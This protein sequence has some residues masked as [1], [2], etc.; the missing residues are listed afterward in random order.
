MTKATQ[1]AAKPA[2]TAAKKASA[3]K[4]A[5]ARKA[6]VAKA[7]GAGK[8]APKKQAVAKRAPVPEDQ[9]R[10]YVEVAAYYIAERRGFSEGD[11]LADWAV[12]EAEIDRLLAEGRLNP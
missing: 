10:H 12:A 7:A 8:A 11:P 3:G 2:A 4:T 9:R 5:P 6:T 1:S